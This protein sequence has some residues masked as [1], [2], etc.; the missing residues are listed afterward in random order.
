MIPFLS[1]K[2]G[3]FRFSG[4]FWIDSSSEDAVDLSL[5]KIA[6][7][8]NVEEPSALAALD[9]I[10][11]KSSW[12]MVFDNADGGYHVVEKFL[13]PGKSGSILITSRDKGLKRVAL[14]ENSLEVQEMGEEEAI[15][16]L[17]QSAMIGSSTAKTM[18]LAQKLVKAVGYVP[19]AIDQ[20]GAYIQSCDC[21]LGDYLELL[22][23]ECAQL[24]SMPD[25]KGASDYGYSTYGT[26]EISMKEIERK[27]TNNSGWQQRAAQ[28]AAQSALML[29]RIFAFF[30]YEGIS[31][32]ILRVA[33]Q[34]YWKRRNEKN[35]LPC[36]I[37]V[38]DS[39]TLFLNGTGEWDRLRF[40][41]GIKI[42]VS[43]SLVKS[44]NKLYSV[45]PL[46]HTWS[47]DRI[48][49]T[50]VIAACNYARALLSCSIDPD[51]GV[52]NYGY[53]G[54]IFRHIRMMLGIAVKLK[55]DDVYYDDESTHFRFVFGRV[56]SWD[57]AEKLD[58][59]VMGAR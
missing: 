6:K 52:D 5:K 2:D 27:A 33:G 40:Q 51:Y 43:F 13:P 32:D 23:E 15:S 24:M 9:W 34:N 18:G 55:A 49:R 54:L 3:S 28:R 45:H 30:H 7:A 39:E 46:V 47:R 41:G 42:L 1:Y 10:S 11:Y 50:E 59:D 48:P 29:F 19:L 57:D 58:L 17:L 26:W 37:A 31:E 36:S 12:L 53:C 8:N 56:G 16:L 14:E 4:I 25:F 38:L 35:E 20:A 21:D 44:D 22:Q